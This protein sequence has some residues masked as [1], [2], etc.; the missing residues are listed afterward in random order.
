MGWF[1]SNSVGEDGYRGQREGIC[2]QYVR[3]GAGVVAKELTCWAARFYLQ[4][5]SLW[6]LFT[7]PLSVS[8]GNVALIV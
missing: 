4:F 3:Y 7:S 6:G 8:L 5:P 2:L 1:V